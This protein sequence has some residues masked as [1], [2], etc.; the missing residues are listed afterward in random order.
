M[1]TARQ[2]LLLSP[3]L[4]AAACSASP[5][6]DAASAADPSVPDPDIEQPASAP[7]PDAAAVEAGLAGLVARVRASDPFLVPL[8]LDEALASP[9]PDCPLITDFGGQD[10][11][12]GD[13]VSTQG[14]HYQGFSLSV[15]MQDVPLEDGRVAD[16]WFHLTAG[17]TVTWPDGASSRIHGDVEVAEVA[18]RDGAP[19][20]LEFLSLGRVTSDR[21]T[22]A[23]S[24]LGAQVDQDLRLQASWGD[25]QPALS[26]EL[27][28]SWPGGDPGAAIV[29]GFSVSRTDDY[30]TVA[31][32]RLLLWW[33]DAGW[34][35]V[36][37]DPGVAASCLA[38][39]SATAGGADLGRVCVDLWPLVDWTVSPW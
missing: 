23:D 24:W 34:A 39:G 16:D 2:A 25:G 10:L 29:E 36:R 22:W 9:D 13:C 31:S 19:R 33:P 4:L 17:L 38:C 11:F 6:T 15:A 37:L 8:F 32:D 18:P 5:S 26:L 30:C 12:D 20:T 14:V 21:D 1:C 3:L 35:D 7:P 27:R 28:Q